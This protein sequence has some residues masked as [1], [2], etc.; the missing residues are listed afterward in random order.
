MP[1]R[2]TIFSNVHFYFLFLSLVSTASLVQFYVCVALEK[3]CLGRSKTWRLSR[4][5]W[6][7]TSSASLHGR[8]TFI[9][10]HHTVP[11]KW[12]LAT[13]SVVDT[14]LTTY[15]Y[16]RC[17]L[18]WRRLLRTAA[19]DTCNPTWYSPSTIAYKPIYLP[20][21]K[22]AFDCWLRS[23]VDYPAP[24]FIVDPMNNGGSFKRIAAHCGY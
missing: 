13:L 5:A 21:L 8:P 3:P 12:Q 6:S 19:A 2:I 9:G 17:S 20:W 14:A 23:W 4:L 7:F 18:G 15:S 22:S 1:L 16:H 10:L 24:L 11:S